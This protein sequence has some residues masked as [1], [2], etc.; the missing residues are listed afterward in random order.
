MT[1]RNP[2]CD[3]AQR[4]GQLV[5][6]FFFTCKS[7]QMKSER[8]A[9]NGGSH[10][11]DTKK[12]SP[13]SSKAVNIFIFRTQLCKNLKRRDLHWNLFSTRDLE[14]GYSAKI[15]ITQYEN[16]DILVLKVLQPPYLS[17][18][19]LSTYSLTLLQICFLQ[20]NNMLAC[21]QPLLL[22]L[23]RKTERRRKEGKSPPAVAR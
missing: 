3:H 5:Q 21:V 23:R 20:S 12:Q 18:D 19:E 16:F 10:S 8:I 22:S 2:L 17:M 4:R 9:A 14:S 13:I 1:L 11:P 7:D 6:K 15:F